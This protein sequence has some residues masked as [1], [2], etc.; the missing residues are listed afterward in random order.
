MVEQACAY[1]DAD[2]LDPRAWHLLGQEE[3][4]RAYLRVFAP[5]E[6]REE[7]VIGRVVTAPSVRGTGL[8]RA[9]MA[10]GLS[11]IEGGWGTVPVWLSAQAHLA[12]F[13]GGFGF[14]VCGPGYDEDGIPHLP[15][16]RA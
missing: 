5:G 2:G 4:L 7:A 3:T 11:R 12:P 10:E 14:A 1:P 6:R 9:L 8:G 15:M 13:Y 16:R